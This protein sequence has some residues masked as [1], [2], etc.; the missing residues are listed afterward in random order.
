M[1]LECIYLEC[2]CTKKIIYIKYIKIY[3]GIY[4]A[5]FQITFIMC[6]SL[7]SST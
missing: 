2:K 6:I 3:K 4:V 1:Y 5:V 7:N